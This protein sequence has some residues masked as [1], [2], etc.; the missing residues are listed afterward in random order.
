MT[1]RIVTDSTCDLPQEIIDQYH[2]TVVPLFI[3]IGTREYRDGVDLSREE[4]YEK[5]PELRPHPTTA[6][7]GIDLFVQTYER[8]IQEGATQIISIH[9][10]PKLSGVLNVAKVAAE[11]IASIPV[12]V[13]DSRSLS[14]GTGFAVYTAAEAA[15][16]GHPIEKILDLLENQITRTRVFAALDSMQYLQRSGRVSFAIST[17]GNFLH[18]KPLLK[19]HNGEYGTEKVRTRRNAMLRLIEMLGEHFPYERVGILYS[20][21]ADRARELLDEVRELLPMDKVWFG[22]LNPVLGTH[23]GPGV[24]GFI[25]IAKE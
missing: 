18:I 2:I 13:L 7:P 4:F 20:G 8:L 5:L 1:I 3:Q 22:I 11:R 9:I 6:V 16:E 15:L 21:A 24:V 10:S 17:I 14:M 25:T 23:L 12:T 19:M